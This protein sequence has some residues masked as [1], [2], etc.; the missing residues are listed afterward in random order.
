MHYLLV[1][2]VRTL[3]GILA[4]EIVEVSQASIGPHRELFQ[5]VHSVDSRGTIRCALVTR[6]TWRWGS[7]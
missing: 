3:S 7:G 1:E 4:F 6:F 2:H 5:S